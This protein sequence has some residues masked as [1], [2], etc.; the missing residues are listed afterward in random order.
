MSNHERVEPFTVETNPNPGTR[1][2]RGIYGDRLEEDPTRMIPYMESEG[3]TEVRQ[4]EDGSWIGIYPLFT[5]WSVCLDVTKDTSYGYRWCFKDYDEALYFARTVK[6]FD[7]IPVKRE[8][9]KGHRYRD[10]PRIKMSNQ[11]GFLRW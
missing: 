1:V 2:N 9:L 11:L 5:T 7:E 3:F 10:D 4:L 8:S 6:E